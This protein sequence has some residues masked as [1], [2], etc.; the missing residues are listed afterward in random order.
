MRL[1]LDKSTI[2]ENQANWFDRMFSATRVP[3]SPE[4]I[5]PIC[6]AKRPDTVEEV[7]SLM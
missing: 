3:A 5:K 1:K 7:R 6:Q 2:Y 4:K